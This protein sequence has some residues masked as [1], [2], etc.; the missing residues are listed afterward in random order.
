M[1]LITGIGLLLLAMGAAFA[2]GLAAKG[3]VVP[4]LGVGAVSAI[5]GYGMYIRTHKEPDLLAANLIDL[6]ALGLGAGQGIDG[7]SLSHVLFFWVLGM[8]DPG[9]PGTYFALGALWEGAETLLGQVPI[10][11]GTGRIM[12]LGPAGDGNVR[13]RDEK[14]YWYG[15]WSD[16][17]LN[18]AGYALGSWMA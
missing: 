9:R 3:A 10:D 14:Q 17:I 16:L 5:T 18:S 1:E 13:S 15:R 12:L 2:Y 6:E 8:L 11:L 7:W 4:A